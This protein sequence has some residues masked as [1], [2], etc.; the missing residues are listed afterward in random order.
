MAMTIEETSARQ[1]VVDARIRELDRHDK[2]TSPQEI[3]Y[4]Q[5][6][7]ESI[8]L[9]R[10][11]LEESYDR[12]NLENGTP[13]DNDD[14][15]GRWGGSLVQRGNPWR[16]SISAPA[17]GGSHDTVAE[18]RGRARTAIERV[19]HAPDGGRDRITR[20]LDT[21]NGGSLAKVAAWAIATS[22]PAYMRAFSKLAVDPQNG[23]RE[24]TGEELNAF[25]R[26]QSLAR[27]M[28]LTDASGGYLVPFQLDPT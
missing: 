14:A 22:D 18:L 15:R 20:A 26:T 19:K 25:Q 17:F 2:L 27:A 13:S 1:R 8:A 12:G 7:T 5:L 23:N 11:I 16:E 24:F 28:S 6:R 3:E 4:Q 9:Q 21:E 10:V